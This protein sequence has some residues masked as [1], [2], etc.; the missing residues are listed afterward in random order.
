[1]YI[2]LAVC[3]CAYLFV[4]FFT[5]IRVDS[6]DEKQVSL[7]LS[8]FFLRQGITLYHLDRLGSQLMPGIPMPPPSQH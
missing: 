8:T 3:A 5:Q 1:M 6:R 7:Y 2:M 4:Y